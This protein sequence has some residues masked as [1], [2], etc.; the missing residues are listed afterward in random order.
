MILFVGDKPSAKNKSQDIP[1]VGTKSYKRLLEWIFEMDL[2]ITDLAITNISQAEFNDHGPEV[3]TH[4]GMIRYTAVVALGKKASKGLTKL[5]IP[6]F[7]LPHP[8]GLNRQCNNKIFISKKLKEC[9]TY[10]ETTELS[11]EQWK[12][13][14]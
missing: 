14:S 6:H 9:K 10:L 3:D 4:W 13:V 7:E 12:T 11:Y 8:S 2:D 1:F 5:G